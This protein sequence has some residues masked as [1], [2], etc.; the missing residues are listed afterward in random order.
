MSTVY[1]SGPSSTAD[2]VLGALSYRGFLRVPTPGLCQPDLPYELTEL[3]DDKLMRLLAEF[4]T[5][6]AYAGS[7]AAIYAVLE[8]EAEVQLDAA[9]ARAA[10]LAK[11]EKSVAAQKAVAAADPA[12]QDAEQQLLSAFAARRFMDAMANGIEKSGAVVS[13]ELS[14]RIGRHD[15]EARSNKWTP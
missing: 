8:K 13:R 10:V 4:T 2:T 14:R 9:R 12:V 7:E 15:R 5:W 1:T 6:A 3:P 11:N